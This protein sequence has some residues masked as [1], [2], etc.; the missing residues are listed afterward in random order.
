MS[1]CYL[2]AASN[3]R[4]SIIGEAVLNAT[5]NEQMGK[6]KVNEE[7]ATAIIKQKRNSDASQAKKRAKE[8]QRCRQTERKRKRKRDPPVPA[9]N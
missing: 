3:H 7:G 4:R 1:R 5:S 9:T 6:S 2:I 8:E